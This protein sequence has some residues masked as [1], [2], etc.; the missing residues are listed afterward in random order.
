MD[1]INAQPLN[2][3]QI[4][5]LD[6]PFNYTTWRGKVILWVTF[7][8]FVAACIAFSISMIVA[9][10]EKIRK[11]SLTYTMITAI[12]ATAY[13]SMAFEQ[14]YFIKENGRQM[15]YARYIDWFFTTPLLIYELATLAG[16]GLPL[17]LA[18]IFF[19]ILMIVTGLFGALT[20]RE[21]VRWGWFAIGCFAFI[22]VVYLIL[23]NFRKYLNEKTRFPYTVQ[24]IYLCGIWLLYPLAWGLTEGGYIIRED[25]EHL[26]FAILDIIAKIFFGFNT[27]FLFR[28]YLPYSEGSI[29][30][31][32]PDA[33][34]HPE[35]WRNETVTK[36]D[37]YFSPKPITPG[38]RNRKNASA[39]ANNRVEMQ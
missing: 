26:W 12:A 10:S 5:G 7:G 28:K 25:W 1:I 14:G 37:A 13:L 35:M 18:A 3:E 31:A 34:R 32:K 22:P 9:K 16:V 20:Y 6:N 38:T 27:I 23:F 17:T 19:D 30:D 4:A 33:P 15:Y 8:L 2:A 36:P 29:A 24:S 21:S 39:T 11:F